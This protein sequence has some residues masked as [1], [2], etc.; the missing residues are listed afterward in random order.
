M[1]SYIN[2]FSTWSQPS[3]KTAGPSANKGAGTSAYQGAG[4]SA[5]QGLPGHGSWKKVKCFR[6]DATGSFQDKN[7]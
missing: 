6:K 1:A 7:K 3:Q 2:L 4:T 5:N